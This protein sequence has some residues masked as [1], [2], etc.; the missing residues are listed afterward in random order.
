MKAKASIIIPTYNRAN[1]LER[2]LRALP[3][4]AEVIVVDDGSEDETSKVP[5]RVA[6]PRL[7]YVRQ[8]NHG[9]A[10]A[11]NLGARIATGEILIFTDDDC[12]PAQGWPWPLVERLRKEPDEIGGVGGAVLP[13]KDGVVSRYSTFHRILE[14]PV[15]CSY[16]VTANCAYRRDAFEAAGGFDETIHTPGGEDPDLAFRV[17]ARG[18]RLVFEPSATV[19]HDYRENLLD[20]AR[21]FYRY[22]KGCAHVLA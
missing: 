8:L 15:S 5:G 11:R 16:L 3:H 19:S 17:R 9:P 18:Y 22:G 7:T 13:L 4:D 21:T 10:V 14:P 1:S 2:C 12:V 20:F 6:H